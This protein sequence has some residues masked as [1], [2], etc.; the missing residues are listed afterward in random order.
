MRRHVLV[1]LVSGLL[2]ALSAR[3]ED[4][5]RRPSWID[6]KAWEKVKGEWAAHWRPIVERTLLKNASSTLVELELRRR[7]LGA[8]GEIGVHLTGLFEAPELTALHAVA[9]ADPT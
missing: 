3:A 6:A 4:E 9:F 1:L 7:R 5:D 2:L 8:E